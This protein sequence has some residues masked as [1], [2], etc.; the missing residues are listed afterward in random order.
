MPFIYHYFWWFYTSTSNVKKNDKNHKNCNSSSGKSDD[1]TEELQEFASSFETFPRTTG[2]PL[3]AAKDMHAPFESSGPDSS[4]DLLKRLQ[5]SKRR[6]LTA[7]QMERCNHEDTPPKR[8]NRG[9]RRP[10]SRVSRNLQADLAPDF[11]F[12]T[13]LTG[14]SDGPN[15]S[16]SSGNFN[17][18]FLRC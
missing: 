6:I 9:H 12:L 1:L 11:S 14:R 18:T 15:T 4:F 7:Q 3:T 13:G 8:P 17:H 5:G 2:V 10:S 16:S